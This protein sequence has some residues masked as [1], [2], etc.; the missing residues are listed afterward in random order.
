MEQVYLIIG[1]ENPV[2]YCDNLGTAVRVLGD[3][4]AIYLNAL[5]HI[6]NK[7]IE[8]SEDG[9]EIIIRCTNKN[10]VMQPEIE[11]AR[12][13]ITTINKLEPLE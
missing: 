8:K 6:Y 5:P 3:Y 10:E 11:L 9:T 13:Y 4:A 12:L 1:H 7:Y 2:G